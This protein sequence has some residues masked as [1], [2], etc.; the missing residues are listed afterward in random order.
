MWFGFK[1]HNVVDMKNGLID[2]TKVTPANTPDFRGL[3][4]EFM[5]KDCMVF[6]DKGYDYEYVYDLCDRNKCHAGII[7][8]KNRKDKNKD[9]DKWISKTRM[10]FEGTFSKLRKRSK[11]RGLKKVQFQCTFE[12][13][14]HNL[15]KAI[16]ILPGISLETLPT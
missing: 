12:S 11:F 9:L 10:P 3:D 1:R 15:K 6:M 14:C 8:K 16:K 4:E 5:P 2:D 7:K 13:M